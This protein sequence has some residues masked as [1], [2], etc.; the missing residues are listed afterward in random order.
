MENGKIRERK[1]HQRATSIK[2]LY[3]FCSSN[4]TLKPYANMQ[5]RYIEKFIAKVYFDIFKVE[6]D[7]EAGSQVLKLGK[8]LFKP[9]K[10]T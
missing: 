7:E 9:K 2:I 10:G 3:P 1:V 8:A 6:G 4:F 5:D